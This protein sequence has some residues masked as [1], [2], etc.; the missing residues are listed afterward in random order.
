MD[1]HHYDNNQR[2]VLGSPS[3]CCS[4]LTHVVYLPVP[5][6]RTEGCGNCHR[7][8]TGCTS[9]T[10]IR[11]ECNDGK[12]VRKCQC[13]ALTRRASDQSDVEVELQT[14]DSDSIF[15]TRS[16]EDH[17]QIEPRL[18]RAT[19]ST[20]NPHLL[21]VN[22]ANTMTRCEHDNMIGSMNICP[23]GH[24]MPIA[25]N[26]GFMFCPGILPTCCAHASRVG[27]AVATPS[28]EK[29]SKSE[30]SSPQ[31][32]PTSIDERCSPNNPKVATD[33][34][35]SNS[36]SHRRLS[37]D[38]GRV[39]WSDS[40]ESVFSDFQFGDSLRRTSTTTT[41]TSVTT[42]QCQFS[43]TPTI[44]TFSR[45]RIPSAPAESK[46]RPRAI[47][48]TDL[49]GSR[50]HSSGSAEDSVFPAF[51]EA[52]IQPRSVSHNPEWEEHK[53]KDPPC[54]TELVT[55]PNPMKNTA[56]MFQI[57]PRTSLNTRNHR[58]SDRMEYMN[59]RN[60]PTQRARDQ[61]VTRKGA[62][63]P[64]LYGENVEGNGPKRSVSEITLQNRSH[65]VGFRHARSSRFSPVRPRLGQVNENHSPPSRRPRSRS[66]FMPPDA[67]QFSAFTGPRSPMNHQEMKAMRLTEKP[68]KIDFTS[69]VRVQKSK[70][71]G[72]VLS[73]KEGIKAY[74]ITAVPSLG[75]FA[76][77]DA[78]K[79]KIKIYGL[80]GEMKRAFGTP[81]WPRYG[82]GITMNPKKNTIVVCHLSEVCTYTLEGVSKD[83]F[84]HEKFTACWGIVCDNKG[85]Y[86]IT[87]PKSSSVFIL[88][89]SGEIKNQIGGNSS[90]RNISQKQLN[91]RPR[92]G[93]NSWRKSN[94]KRASISD[95]NMSDSIRCLSNLSLPISGIEASRKIST[96]SANGKIQVRLLAP[97]YVAVNSKNQI[98]VSDT[99]Q[100]CLLVFEEDGT[101][102]FS[103]GGGRTGCRKCKNRRKRQ[104][105]RVVERT[106]YSLSQ[107]KII[108]WQ[109]SVENDAKKES[110]S[111]QRKLSISPL[112]NTDRAR[113]HS[114]LTDICSS[115]KALC[116]VKHERVR[117]LGTIYRGNVGRNESVE[118][119]EY[120]S[121]RKQV[122]EENPVN[123]EKNV[124]QKCSPSHSVGSRLHSHGN[125]ASEQCSSYI[126]LTE[127]RNDEQQTN[128]S[129]RRNSPSML[130]KIAKN[131]GKPL[132]RRRRKKAKK[133]MAS[134][135]ARCESIGSLSEDEQ[136]VTE[137]SENRNGGNYGSQL[138]RIRETE[139]QK[140]GI[141]PS[142]NITTFTYSSERKSSADVVNS[143]TEINA[144]L[145]HI[146]S[147]GDIISDDNLNDYSIMSFTS[148]PEHEFEN[149]S[150]DEERLACRRCHVEDPRGVCVDEEDNILLVDR[151]RNRVTVFT[152]E[153]HFIRHILTDENGLNEPMAACVLHD[154]SLA[155]T[156]SS[157]CVK[158][159]QF[160]EV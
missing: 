44:Q 107:E 77:T 94:K 56:F 27:T 53:E 131:I 105:D 133:L 15:R 5:V 88:S 4:C 52:M 124:E 132:W 45:M 80:D 67:T 109:N 115:S 38:S 122:I 12:N 148:S 69:W 28:C 154:G 89:P 104:D 84:A 81:T 13:V 145:K 47:S 129:S 37:A 121:T 18:S 54:T 116:K 150:D 63:S 156:D 128:Q 102:L 57:S 141:S 65:S 142:T 21:S 93:L 134:Q 74:G 49:R 83:R 110:P 31:E 11:H 113:S 29:C 97:R 103:I 55:P 137:E 144:P 73:T 39:T 112:R 1:H 100:R 135:V 78:D 136:G 35:T 70:E 149:E 118:S 157:N 82:R 58:K 14:S 32:T 126:D 108:C 120:L 90:A 66:L 143:P 140:P 61:E 96:S 48:N 6:L 106:L 87:D 50:Q 119:Q 91:S 95:R 86:V 111:S 68:E 151:A 8:L 3:R 46:L 79:V 146:K 139:Y 160:G 40:G 62:S 16:S 20:S 99:R 75:G 26:G 155:V 59:E 64:S 43:L 24:L 34:G 147:E 158:I 153:G 159:F 25:R 114:F 123:E 30:V 98:L 9:C 41:R 60:K 152:P 33:E 117:V 51:T 76:V 2:N 23:G 127:G 17:R 72:G 22:T 7:I 101:L 36:R 19:A 125:Q 10:G 71:I 92:I 85:N 138:N 130:T 42:S